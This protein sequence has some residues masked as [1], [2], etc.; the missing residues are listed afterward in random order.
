MGLFATKKQ[1]NDEVSN[2]EKLT[3]FKKSKNILVSFIIFTVLI[4]FLLSGATITETLS[5]VDG[6][7]L[8]ISVGMN[9]I[10]AFF[11]YQNHRWAMIV[12]CLFFVGDKIMYILGGAPA[13]PQLIFAVIV[14]MATVSSYRVA[15]QLK[16]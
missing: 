16:K 5:V 11:I 14:I 1:I 6:N 7:F 12:F 3:F 9:L 4:T 13:I 8:V 15:D 10:L 2:Y